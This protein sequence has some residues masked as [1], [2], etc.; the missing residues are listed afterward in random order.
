MTASPINRMG[1]LGGGRLPGSLA[2][3]HD[4]HQHS[5]APAR[6]PQAVALDTALTTSRGTPMMP[7]PPRR[8]KTVRRGGEATFYRLRMVPWTWTLFASSSG[9]DSRTV[10]YRVAE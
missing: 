5:A 1:C 4:A 2:E 9:A 6:H 8:S 10:V 7:P 3:R